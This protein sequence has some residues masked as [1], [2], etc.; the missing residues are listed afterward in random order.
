[1]K[2]TIDTDTLDIDMRESVEDKG[3]DPSKLLT[4]IT[5]G[6][7]S[8][9]AGFAHEKLKDRD[10]RLRYVEHVRECLL[11]AIKMAEDMDEYD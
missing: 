7:C 11:L 10:D 8:V 2:I 5:N 4:E 6:F 9:M 1:M 3:K